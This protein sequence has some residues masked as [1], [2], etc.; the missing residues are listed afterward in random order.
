MVHTRA[1][2]KKSARSPG[3]VGLEA[4]QFSDEEDELSGAP[5][6]T[7][8][9]RGPILRVMR[10][11]SGVSDS[12]ISIG[13]SEASESSEETSPER[14]NRRS[15]RR[16]TRANGT[17]TIRSSYAE[18][19]SNRSTRFADDNDG[20]EDEEDDESSSVSESGLFVLQ[21]DL[22][23][24]S[25]KRKR[26][27]RPAGPRLVIRGLSYDRSSRTNARRSERSTRAQGN[28]EEVGVDEIYRSDSDREPRNAVTKVS[29]AREAFKNLPRDDPFRLRHC[30]QCD[31]CGDGSNAGSLIY[32]QGCTLSYHK[33]CIGHRTGREHLVTKV[34]EG[35]FV[36]QCRRCVNVVQRRD[37]TAPNQ[38]KCQSCHE[39]GPSCVP[40]RERKTPLQEQREREENNGEDPIADVDPDLVDNVDHV[41]FRC[42]NCWRACH[43]HH[44]PPR[45]QL[46][47]DIDN[48]DDDERA[49]QR[50][51]EYSRDWRCVD[52]VQMPAKVS[53]I[54]AWRPAD[55]ETY[56]AGFTAEMMDE[57]EKEYLIKWD[58]LSYFRATWMP[59][60]WVWGVTAPAM[61][62]AFS[63]REN[64]PRMRT[65][66]A[67]PEEYLRIDIVLDIRY[68]SIVDTHAEEVDKAR[69]KEVDEAL[70]KYK[71]L[72]YEDAVWEKVPTPE[73]G[74]RWTD[75]VTA[76]NDWVLGRYVHVPKA[77]PLKNRLEKARVQPFTQLEKKKQPENLIGGELMKYQLD[78]L[79]WLYYQWY[80]QR[81]GI[82]ADEMGLGKTIQV[83]AFLATLVCLPLSRNSTY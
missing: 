2:P 58:K 83:I 78:G 64:G 45:N 67:V 27:G 38:G 75:F 50:L 29:G 13:S 41:L 18:T 36:L 30:Q 51:N 19:I 5:A 73:D 20:L 70:I 26:L 81:N 69:I 14:L 53:G 7:S 82:L 63:K 74:D 31:T 46:H 61:R 28:M 17:R 49:E 71:G 12:H 43:F 16:L 11:H 80:S 8:T 40:F 35:E 66:D 33:Q 3:F 55:V 72:G 68:T 6:Q 60:P 34:G 1:R 47:M 24:K 15:S 57:E 56:R 59:G 77:G 44:L 32:C 10:G 22:G 25:R 23:P 42:T 52:C 62:K 39:V 4:L 76:Y 48:V 37:P 79:N 54:I 21:S 65:E 9:R